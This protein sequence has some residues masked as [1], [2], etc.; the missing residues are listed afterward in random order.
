MA[1]A[2]PPIESQ[3]AAWASFL[4]PLDSE[5]LHAFCLDIER[6]FRINP[7][8][9]FDSWEQRGENRYHFSGRNS[10]QEPALAFALDLMVEPT[11]DGLII[12]YAQ[13]L[14]SSTTLRIEAEEGKGSKLTIIEDYSGVS[15]AERNER[16]QEVDKSLTR[17]AGDLQAFLVM[18]QRWSW[19]SPWRW[20]MHRIWQPLKPTGRRI[21]YMFIWISIVEVALIALGAAIYWNEYS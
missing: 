18:W 5:A 15:E 16:L 2:T 4:A 6:L 13:G 12:R 21:V 14:K 3:D 9:E 1:E 19:L 7:Y 10:S 11:P 20:Y 17:W 8:L